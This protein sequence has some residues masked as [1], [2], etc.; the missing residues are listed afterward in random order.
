MSV[1]SITVINFLNTT[2]TNSNAGF[3][4][5]SCSKKATIC[6]LSFVISACQSLAE[7]KQVCID[8]SQI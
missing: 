6:P 2:R 8:I 7:M 1:I 4:L 5:V 3:H